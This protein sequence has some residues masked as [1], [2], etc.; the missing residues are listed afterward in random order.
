MALGVGGVLELLEDDRARLVLEFLGLGDRALH[1]V[2]ARGEDDFRTVGRGEFA[3]LNGHGVRHRED[4]VVAL[5]GAHEREA[6]ARVA[7]R[8]LHDRR[9]RLEGARLFGG[10]DHRER[11]AVLHAAARVEVLDLGE[12]ARAAVVELVGDF[13]ER[14]VADLVENGF[15]DL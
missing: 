9:A 10:L 14:R 8:G 13:D 6:D 3:P 7:A 5:D 1:A 2:R 15:C 12:H 11:D 4:E